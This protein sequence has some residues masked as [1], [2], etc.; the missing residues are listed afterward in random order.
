M[1]LKLSLNR[2]LRN[3]EVASPYFKCR[4]DMGEKEMPS[5][6]QMTA[7][8]HANPLTRAMKNNRSLRC[9]VRVNLSL[10]RRG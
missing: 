10:L 1:R 9:V 6:E 4:E 8:Q 2:S 7:P 3:F 5:H